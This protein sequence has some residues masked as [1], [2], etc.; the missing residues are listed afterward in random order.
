MG[1][2]QHIEAKIL[3]IGLHLGMALC[4]QCFTV[5]CINVHYIEIDQNDIFQIFQIFYNK[6]FCHLLEPKFS[7]KMGSF[8]VHNINIAKKINK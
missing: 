6:L 4:Y 7:W 1:Q 5:N 8:E 3:K 2:K